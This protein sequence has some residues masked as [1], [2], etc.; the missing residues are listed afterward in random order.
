MIVMEKYKSAC[1]GDN[2]ALLTRCDTRKIVVPGRREGCKCVTTA[3]KLPP[4]AL[5][6]PYQATSSNTNCNATQL[7]T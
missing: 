1:Y 7:G 6:E 2:A 5:F 4:I 3:E